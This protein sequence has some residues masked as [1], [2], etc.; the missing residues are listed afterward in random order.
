MILQS[1]PPVLHQSHLPSGLVSPLLPTLDYLASQLA[2]YQFYR[3]EAP[4]N[5]LFLLSPQCSNMIYQIY[6]DSQLA[7]LIYPVVMNILYDLLLMC[8]YI[9]RLLQ[10]NRSFGS[11]SDAM[12]EYYLLV[13]VSKRC[14]QLNAGNDKEAHYNANRA[15]V[16]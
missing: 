10:D 9:E 2:S 4:Q 1:A 12:S 15:A 6:I 7:M 13:A 11:C 14:K 5:A 8:V 3:K 16:L